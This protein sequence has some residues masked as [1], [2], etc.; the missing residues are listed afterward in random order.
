MDTMTGFVG[1]LTVT[2]ALLGGAILTGRAGK[3][4]LHLSLVASMLVALGIT[5]YFAE[6]LGDLYDLESAGF[7]TPLH[8]TLAKI[9]VLAYF[10][11]LVSGWMTFRGREGLRSFHAKAA[12]AV[13]AITVVTLLTGTAMILMSERLPA[14][15]RHEPASIPP[16]QTLD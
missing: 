3:R 9:T 13:V 7:I 11:P 8:L 16:P 6:R 12:Y 10:V 14:A 15:E 5:I 4:R 1:F 2:V